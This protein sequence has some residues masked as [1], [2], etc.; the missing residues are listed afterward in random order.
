MSGDEAHGTCSNNGQSILKNKISE[1]SLV[2]S[3][4]LL[5]KHGRKKAWV[6][7]F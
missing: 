4:H 1:A 3:L 7:H 5:F 6:V 2:E